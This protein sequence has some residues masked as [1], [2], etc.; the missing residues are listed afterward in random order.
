MLA[1]GARETALRFEVE[2]EVFAMIG[3]LE[4]QLLAM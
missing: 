1:A 2:D 3:D 4:E